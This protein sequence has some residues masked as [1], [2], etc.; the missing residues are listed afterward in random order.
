[1]IPIEENEPF[2]LAITLIRDYFDKNK[3]NK[4][5]QLLAI[6]AMEEIH[7]YVTADDM[8]IDYEY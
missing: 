7:A 6:K 2:E 4:R 8:K 1:M 3:N 5:E